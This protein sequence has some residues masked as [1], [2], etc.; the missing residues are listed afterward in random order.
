MLSIS[1]DFGADK[2]I[3]LKHNNRAQWH[4]NDGFHTKIAQSARDKVLLIQLC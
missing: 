3:F 4:K 2:K 1:R